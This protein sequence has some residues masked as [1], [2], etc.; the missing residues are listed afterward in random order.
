MRFFL[1]LGILLLWTVIMAQTVSTEHSAQDKKWGPNTRL[2]KV[3]NALGQNSRLHA[4]ENLDSTLVEK[5]KALVT[6]GRTTKPNGKKTSRQSKYYVCTDCH[7]I[8]PENPDLS[9]PNPKDRLK[10]AIKQDIPFLQ[11]TTLYGVVNR[12]TW[13]N[14]DYQKKYG[15]EAKDAK[16]TLSNAIQLC[17]T[18]CAQGRLLTEWEMKAVMHFL[19]SIELRLGDLDLP[20]TVM[21]RLEK[22]PTDSKSN[23]KLINKLKNYYYLA[24]EATFADALKV[25][26][27]KKGKTGDPELGKAIY[28]K[29]CRHCHKA[30]GP[31]R[32]TLDYSVLSFN[33]LFKHFDDY[34]E[35]S[36]YQITRYG[37][38]PRKGYR[39]YMPQYPL[40]RMSRKQVE[41]LAAFI[42]QET[43]KGP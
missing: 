31:T 23:K 21:D 28:E 10:H 37:T 33:K 2:S 42:R 6:R 9:N 4:V 19:W 36:I 17:A 40:E 15:A 38:S 27:R 25:E 13:Y 39:P 29:G 35:H 14:G 8:Q 3:L 26:E 5:G 20:K 30:S 24:S 43:T 11:G 34:K 12:E 16:D 7:N 41:H 22:A 18:Q 32:F 1:V